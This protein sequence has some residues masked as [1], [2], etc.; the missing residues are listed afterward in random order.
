M[1]SISKRCCEAARK[2]CFYKKRPIFSVGLELW[3]SIALSNSLMNA[4]LTTYFL[5]QKPRC[6][7]LHPCGYIYFRFVKS[8][9]KT[10][11]SECK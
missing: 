1:S 4:S 2:N 10:L 11:L 8:A 3:M 6:V 5:N 9:Q 7:T